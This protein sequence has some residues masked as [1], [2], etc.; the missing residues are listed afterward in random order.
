MG[1]GEPLAIGVVIA[2][3]SN[4]RSFVNLALAL[5]TRR[6]ESPLSEPPASDASQSPRHQRRSSHSELG[7]KS[8]CVTH[9]PSRLAIC[10]APSDA[11]WQFEERSQR[12]TSLWCQLVIAF[13]RIENPTVFHLKLGDRRK[14]FGNICAEG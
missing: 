1:D 10:D 11:Q 6:L 9:G 12:L 7:D 8:P 13:N 4:D 5:L 14:Y 3:H 2:I